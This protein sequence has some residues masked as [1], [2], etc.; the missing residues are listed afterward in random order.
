M[1]LI[2]AAVALCAIVA[3]CASLE[4]TQQGVRDYAAM[5]CNELATEAKR[6]WRAKHEQATLLSTKSEQHLA[7]EREQAKRDLKAVKKLAADKECLLPS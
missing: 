4:P 6:L 3:G 1:P 2:I 5:T 7:A